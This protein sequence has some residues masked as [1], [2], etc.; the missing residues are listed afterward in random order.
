MSRNKAARLGLL[1]TAAAAVL[2]FAHSGQVP[3]EDASKPIIRRDLIRLTAPVFPPVKR[4][5]FS[6]VAFVGGRQVLGDPAARAGFPPE[7]EA[8]PV[9]D[10]A[11][12][13]PVVRFVG[14]ILIRNKAGNVYTAL[15][16]VDGAAS[17]VSVG[18]TFG[19]GWKVLNITEK[20]LMVQD[21]D[22]TTQVF[23]FQGE[24]R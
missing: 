6:V 10:A 14:S 21:P 17:A 7:R 9:V 3:A 15:V 2:V 16:L 4:D 24:R 5:P 1:G 12:P 11:P 22:G 19:R 8:P 20:E 13:A 18:D 23:V